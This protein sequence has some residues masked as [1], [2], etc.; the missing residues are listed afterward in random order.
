MSNMIS[1][2]ATYY[3]WYIYLLFQPAEVVTALFTGGTLERE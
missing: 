1:H 3:Y 2:G